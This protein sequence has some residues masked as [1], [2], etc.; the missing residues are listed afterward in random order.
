M[1]SQYILLH[2]YNI[3]M[4]IRKLTLSITV[5]LIPQTNSVFTSYLNNVLY[6]KRIHFQIRCCIQFQV[7]LVFFS[8]NSSLVSFF[9]FLAFLKIVLTFVE[10]CMTL[11]LSE[12]PHY[13]YRSCIIWQEYHRSDAAFLSWHPCQITHNFNLSHC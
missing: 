8:L 11:G 10:W 12:C 7:S 4:K 3:T 13:K 1:Y 5:I 2:H 6:S 9:I